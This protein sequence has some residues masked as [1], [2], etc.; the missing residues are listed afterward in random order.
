MIVLFHVVIALASLL[1]VTFSLFRPSAKLI[2]INYI[3]IAATII[4]GLVLVIIEPA[5]MLH[6]CLAG[7]AYLA[8]TITA[9]VMVQVRITRTE[10]SESAS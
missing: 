10:K 2:I 7:L 3:S 1:A 6:T 5:R 4:S 8:L 9:S